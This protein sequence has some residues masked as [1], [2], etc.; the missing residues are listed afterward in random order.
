MSRGD[1]VVVALQGDAGKPCPA[2]IVTA[3]LAS[4]LDRVALLP[5]TTFQADLPLLRVPLEPN[6]ATGLTARS[7]AV[8]DRMTTISRAKVGKVVGRADAATMRAVNRALL[9][10]LGLV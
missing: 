6:A 2:L 8:L 3:D 1:I 10:F 9:A 4:D 7:D 5:L